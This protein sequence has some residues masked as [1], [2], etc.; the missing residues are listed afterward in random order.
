MT[1]IM[2]N[3]SDRGHTIE[4]SFDITSELGIIESASHDIDRQQRKVAAVNSGSK[5]AYIQD[6]N[7]VFNIQQT[8]TSDSFAPL[9][10]IGDVDDVNSELTI[11]DTLPEFTFQNQGDASNYLEFTGAKWGE[12]TVSFSTADDGVLTFEFTGLAKTPTIET[13]TLSKIDYS[14]KPSRG[15]DI[16]VKIDDVEVGELQSF[17]ATIN[18]NI[19][20]RNAIGSNSDGPKHIVEGLQNITID[21][22]SMNISNTDAWEDVMGGTSLSS[23]TNNKNLKIELPNGEVLEF[24]SVS[25]GDIDPEEQTGEDGTRQ[26]NRTGD[27]LSMKVNNWG[28]V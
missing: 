19:E 16:T 8:I 14:I 25:F 1:D 3:V 6:T 12:C 21:E 11:P 27:A 5:F 13:G 15:Q 22:F 10:L 23:R 9:R 24:T 2:T 7:A 18:R 26:V 4:D 20:G 28:G 17:S